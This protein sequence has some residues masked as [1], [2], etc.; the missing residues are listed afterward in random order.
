[1]GKAADGFLF[2]CDPSKNKECKK[3][4]C[5]L[6]GGPCHNTRRGIYAKDPSKV[7]MVVSTDAGT[8]NKEADNNDN[9][10]NI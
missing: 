2:E 9:S 5:H 4:A 8:I 7:T 3:T 10:G 1:M 6:N